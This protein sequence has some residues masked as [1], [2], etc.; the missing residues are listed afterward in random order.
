MLAFDKFKEFT[1][2]YYVFLF[3]SVK[4]RADSSCYGRLF[5][6]RMPV[7][8]ICLLILPSKPS[9]METSVSVTAPFIPAIHY[10]SA[11]IRPVTEIP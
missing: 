4:G 5:F 2:N 6:A 11:L 7:P 1:G 10:Y 3:E 8:T 9:C